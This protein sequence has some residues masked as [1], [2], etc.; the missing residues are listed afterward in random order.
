VAAATLDR[1]AA[2]VAVAG[3]IGI[4]AYLIS[5]QPA[6]T[7][8][9][10]G[11]VTKVAELDARISAS[12]AADITLRAEV[13]ELKSAI[14]GWAVRT[15]AAEHGLAELNTHF[16]A[17]VPPDPIL[18]A[19]L[20]TLQA[21][22]E[23]RIARLEETA[24]SPMADVSLRSDVD[25]LQA[26]VKAIADGNA[27]VRAELDN[28]VADIDG[29]IAALI[30]A[31]AQPPLVQAGVEAKLAELDVGTSAL[32]ASDPG[33]RA[34][35]D[36]LK[37][38]FEGWRSESARAGE[39]LN[40]KLADLGQLV[41]A[42]P[43]PDPSWRT[44]LETLRAAVESQ[45]R[46]AAASAAELEQRLADLN[47]LWAESRNPWADAP[48]SAE[49][50]SRLEVRVAEIEQTQRTP[51]KPHRVLETL[52]FKHASS[53]LGDE[54]AGKL[55]RIADGMAEKSTRVAIIGFTDTVGPPDYNRSLSLRRAAKVRTLLLGLGV[56]PASIISVDG[57]GEDSTP[58][59]TAD[60]EASANNRAVVVY[61]YE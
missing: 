27:A 39:I 55:R 10:T 23:S 11:A 33:L 59:R 35:L 20:I 3:V 37:S 60:G 58:V 48:S 5:E 40:N 1:I 19:D 56:E 17:L 25:A 13:D 31:N 30:A 50:L 4:G 34:D 18:R 42:L 7:K 2:Y 52:Y 38:T 32:I 61:T 45:S 47:A 12:S 28:K 51:A 24:T 53:E 43:T 44:E 54:E 9:V 57:V 15:V 21:A 29:R 49:A 41:A 16:A 26:A 36:A 8:A 22:L 6:S 46:Q 14:E